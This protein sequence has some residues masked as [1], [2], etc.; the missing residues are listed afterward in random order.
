MPTELVP[1]RSCRSAEEVEAVTL[2]LH[3]AGIP[4]R[5]GS[6]AV[7]FDLTQIGTERDAQMIVTIRPGDMAAATT[8][9]ANAEQEGFEG[10]D[11]DHYFHGYRDDELAQVLVADFEWS[12]HDVA[13]ARAILQERNA[14]PTEESIAEARDK[15]LELLRMG[16]QGNRFL[17]IFGFLI[18][19][20]AFLPWGVFPL[21]VVSCLIGWSFITMK[22]T[23]ALGVT[24]HVYDEPSRKEGR[25]LV[26][27]SI[28]SM[29]VFV[30]FLLF[31][32]PDEL[33]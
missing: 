9:V 12:A 7:N 33:P 8:A 4:F 2:V 29:V 1:F 30:L 13:T 24:Y 11:K 15:Y 18:A 14:L 19:I 31:G 3:E 5:T 17:L 32:Y 16:V 22:K 10:P 23:D 6:N 26:K 20:F 21:G 27:F 25:V 28:F